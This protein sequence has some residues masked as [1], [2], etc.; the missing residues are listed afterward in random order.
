MSLLRWAAFGAV[1][2]GLLR[3]PAPAH[4]GL[5]R[6]VHLPWGSGP[7]QVGRTVPDE[8]A[9]EGPMSLDLD[10]KGR[11]FLLDQVNARILVLDGERVADTW[12][13]HADSYQDLAWIDDQHVALL[14]RLAARVVDV[15][16]HQ[17][18]ILATVPVEGGP[19]QEGG[20][21]TALEVEDDGIWLELEHAQQVRV[22]DRQGRAEK[23]R[24]LRGGRLS[25]DRRVRLSAVR[26]GAHGVTL[27][28]QVATRSD[29]PTRHLATLGFAD[30][31]LQ[32]T[33]LESDARGQVFVGA[34]TFREGPRPPFELLAV[35]EWLV[36]V[37]PDGVA[38]TR[39][40]LPAR[41]GAEEQ[42]RPLRVAP[43]GRVVFV[44][45]DD[46]GVTLWEV[47]P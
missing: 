11:V 18:R 43:D 37:D 45:C 27:W 47:T 29:A 21:V 13:L 12:P 7:D 40:A 15:V 2:F 1:I 33:A 23:V 16:D 9:P 26:D 36:V 38:R 41:R 34:Q 39:V 46:S 6:G 42:F 8:A 30:S 19:V 3:V 20:A 10:G 22:A 28:S 4:A 44:H 14:D 32:I 24:T 25:A 5:E 35:D 17:G 31:L